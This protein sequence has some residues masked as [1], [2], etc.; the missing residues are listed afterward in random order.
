MV[1]LLDQE[2]LKKEKKSGSG[3]EAV[4][5]QAEEQS[6]EVEGVDN[7][8]DSAPSSQKGKEAVVSDPRKNK[9]A[10]KKVTKSKVIP[11]S[12][13]KKGGQNFLSFWVYFAGALGAILVIL[14]AVR[15]PFPFIF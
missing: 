10:L 12:L 2:K 6:D 3:E 11:K 14:F 13:I 15:L 7:S 1:L 4:E 9:Q 8:E 5:E